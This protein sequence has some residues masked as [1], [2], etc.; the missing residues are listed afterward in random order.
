ML[1]TLTL[2]PRTPFLLPVKAVLRA[3]SAPDVR[4]Y[5]LGLVAVELLRGTGG[6]VDIRRHTIRVMV[7]AV[8][9]VRQLQT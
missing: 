7:N 3:M 9:H 4:F 8:I 6:G 5:S 1:S 2:K